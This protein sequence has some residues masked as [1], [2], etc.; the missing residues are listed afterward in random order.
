[1][2]K[3]F[4]DTDGLYEMRIEVKSN[5]LDIITESPKELRLTES[6]VK[7]LHNVLLKIS[8]KDDWH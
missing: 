8:D 5:A 3:F 2:V 4:A 1:M 6:P 7:N